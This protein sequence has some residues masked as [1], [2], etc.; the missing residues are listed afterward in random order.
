[1]I[2]LP[3]LSFYCTVVQNWTNEAPVIFIGELIVG[4]RSY[5]TLVVVV[6]RRFVKACAL[7]G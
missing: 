4:L 6:I 1:M 2:M 3:V 7:L 5:L